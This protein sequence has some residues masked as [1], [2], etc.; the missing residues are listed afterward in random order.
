GGCVGPPL[1]EYFL[2]SFLSLNMCCSRRPPPRP[3]RS[4]VH[5][6]R[7]G[8]TPPRATPATKYDGVQ[9][10]RGRE[11]HR[12]LVEMPELIEDYAE[13]PVAFLVV[14]SHSENRKTKCGIAG[15]R[16]MGWR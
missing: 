11:L 14:R 5:D 15:L 7:P 13:H 16:R 9:P 1:Q 8:S 10:D 3:P 12:R 4:P 2:G 6:A